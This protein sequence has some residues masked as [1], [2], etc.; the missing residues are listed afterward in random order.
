MKLSDDI[1]NY[2]SSNILTNKIMDNER[3]LKRRKKH[4]KNFSY[5]QKNLSVEKLIE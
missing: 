5:Y 3:V 4:L 2:S 1:K